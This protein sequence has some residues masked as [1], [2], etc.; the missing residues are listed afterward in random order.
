MLGSPY[1]PEA[2]SRHRPV[3]TLGRR[4]A[5]VCSVMLVRSLAVAVTLAVAGCASTG[6]PTLPA[7]IEGISYEVLTYSFCGPCD[8]GFMLVSET[9]QASIEHRTWERRGS[10]DRRSVLISRDRYSAFKATLDPYRP[11]T[12]VEA[13]DVSCGDYTTHIPDIRITWFDSGGSVSRVFR[14]GCSHDA[15]DGEA[16]VAA[17]DVLGL[18]V[19]SREWIRR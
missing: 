4:P 12:D 11:P 3:R 13:T 16:V 7:G 14:P 8:G 10:V 15:A 19:Q 18:D 1:V 2:R 5:K 17:P 6:R 9:G